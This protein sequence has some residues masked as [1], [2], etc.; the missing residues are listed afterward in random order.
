MDL[1]YG[2]THEDDD[3]D[4]NDD[5]IDFVRI[6]IKITNFT[7]FVIYFADISIM[8]WLNKYSRQSDHCYL[9]PHN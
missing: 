9:S 3:D 4:D 1:S 5:K 7:K 8:I 2:R 6:N